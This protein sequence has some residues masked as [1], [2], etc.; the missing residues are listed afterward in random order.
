MNQLQRVGIAVVL[1][2]ILFG[3][4]VHYSA[5]Y[6]DHRSYV[7]NE[8][9]VTEYEDHVGEE[10]L[11]FGTVRSVENSTLLIAVNSEAGSFN[12]TVPE[13]RT[14]V[15][16][17]GVIQVYGT[18]KPDHTIQSENVVVV[19]SAGSSNLYKYG[20]SAVGALLVIVLFF[21]H[22]T[23]DTDEWCFEVRADG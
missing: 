23:I 10:T 16:E 5:G 14:S 20:V 7:E 2:G 1:L 12:M 21:R 3:A 17:G 13:T 4:F 9:L 8:R 6:N 11:L 22:W 18:L 19:N 15:D